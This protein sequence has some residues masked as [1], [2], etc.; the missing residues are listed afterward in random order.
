MDKHIL[1]G[2]PKQVSSH[3]IPK[4]HS[5]RLRRRRRSAVFGCNARKFRHSK[6]FQRQ[7]CANFC[8]GISVRLW[9][10]LG[11]ARLLDDFRSHFC[12]HQAVAKHCWPTLPICF[13]QCGPQRPRKTLYKLSACS[14]SVPHLSSVLQF[15]QFCLMSTMC[16]LPQ[17]R[18]GSMHCTA[19]RVL[20]IKLMVYGTVYHNLALN[21][22]VCLTSFSIRAQYKNSVPF[23]F[24]FLRA[25]QWYIQ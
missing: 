7:I 19:D 20:S 3:V 9:K 23:S 13:H 2:D 6:E 22:S 15:F 21:C 16:I 8:P 11:M 4:K 1:I 25:S 5:L 17:G 10:A 18:T 12:P 24:D 14:K